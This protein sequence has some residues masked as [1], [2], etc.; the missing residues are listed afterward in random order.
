MR[1]AGRTLGQGRVP[2]TL[3]YAGFCSAD[4]VA[5]LPVIDD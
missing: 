2:T 5:T 1:S 4:D 3:A